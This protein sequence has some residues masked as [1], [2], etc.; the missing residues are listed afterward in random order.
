MIDQ[1]D[2]I[3]SSGALNIVRI[4]TTFKEFL[5]NI[6]ACMQI[7]GE[8]RTGLSACCSSLLLILRTTFELLIN[9][10]NF[11][12]D[13]LKPCNSIYYVQGSTA[14]KYRLPGQDFL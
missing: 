4:L 14:V 1:L 2:L 8:P 11:V 10:A 7:F 13:T 5:C 12:N 3:K 6:N 9:V